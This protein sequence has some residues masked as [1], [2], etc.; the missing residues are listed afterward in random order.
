MIYNCSE[1]FNIYKTVMKVTTQKSKI[2]IEF[3]MRETTFK[4]KTAPITSYLYFACIWDTR[5]WVR[6]R[7]SRSLCRDISNLIIRV[8]NF[9]SLVISTI[10]NQIIKCSGKIKRLVVRFVLILHY[11]KNLPHRQY[12]TLVIKFCAKPPTPTL[13]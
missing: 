5:F 7:S 4:I 12:V 10:Q 8:N 6:N 1:F 11:I 2:Y 9:Q 3:W 13:I